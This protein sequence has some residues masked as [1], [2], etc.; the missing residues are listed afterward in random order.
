MPQQVQPSTILE[1]TLNFGLKEWQLFQ[2]FILKPIL[3]KIEFAPHIINLIK[4]VVSVDQIFQSNLSKDKEAS[5]IKEIAEYYFSNSIFNEIG[6]EVS[7]ILSK[8]RIMHATYSTSPML[9]KLQI[10]QWNCNSLNSNKLADL[11]QCAKVIELGL[12]VYKR[13]IIISSRKSNCLGTTCYRK[14]RSTNRKEEG[15]CNFCS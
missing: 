10:L 3:C 8:Y 9:A 13:L 1:L 14:D 15:V 11:I 6:T 12:S 4:Y 7:S 5:T 2:I